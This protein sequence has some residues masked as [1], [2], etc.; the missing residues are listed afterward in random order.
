M[1]IDITMNSKFIISIPVF[2]ICVAPPLFMFL[3]GICKS[4]TS[5]CFALKCNVRWHL[6]PLNPHKVHSSVLPRC[7][8]SS[9]S[10]I[11]TRYWLISGYWALDRLFLLRHR[12]WAE[13]DFWQ[14]ILLLLPIMVTLL[15]F[16]RSWAENQL[17]IFKIVIGS[18]RLI[19]FVY[20]IIDLVIYHLMLLMGL[21]TF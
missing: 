12:N 1:Y 14:L 7:W 17:N 20:E 19:N 8:I 18:I 15:L 9:P 21:W 13:D 10:S 4:M 3:P 16:E 2:V 6:L 11:G 5:L